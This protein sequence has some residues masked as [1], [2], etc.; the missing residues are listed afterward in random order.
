[1]S[2]AKLLKPLDY[3]AQ[4]KRDLKRVLGRGCDYDRLDEIVGVLRRDEKLPANC[5]DHKLTG[6]WIGHRECHIAPD[7]LLNYKNPVDAVVLVRT[8]SHS[9]LFGM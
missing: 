6:S 2:E 5:R 1:M 8:G 4:F 3:T 7:W 9:D